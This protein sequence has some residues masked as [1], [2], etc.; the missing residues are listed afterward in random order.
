M[1]YVEIFNELFSAQTEEGKEWFKL[2]M[3]SNFIM[4]NFNDENLYMEYLITIGKFKKYHG[5]KVIE[6]CV[7]ME[8]TN[9]RF[10]F[11]SEDCFSISDLH[12]GI[13]NIQRDKVANCKAVIKPDDSINGWGD[14]EPQYAVYLIDFTNNVNH[15]DYHIEVKVYTEYGI[16]CEKEHQEFLEN[17]DDN[18]NDN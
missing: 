13:Y 16:K 12:T 9:P 14:S 3:M 6:P 8:L 1:N 15:M 17:N 18:K 5:S 11:L 2:V 10:R 7:S 4:D